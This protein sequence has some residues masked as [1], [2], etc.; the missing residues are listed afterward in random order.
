MTVSSATPLSLSPTEGGEVIVCAACDKSIRRNVYSWT[1]GWSVARDYGG[2]GKQAFEVRFHNDPS[3]VGTMLQRM[4]DYN[5]ERRM[6]SMLE[7]K[8]A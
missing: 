3:C 7:A 8:R 4:E 6:A 5:W 1:I 2:S